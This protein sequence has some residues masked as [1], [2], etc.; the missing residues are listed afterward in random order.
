[1]QRGHMLMLSRS[2]RFFLVPLQAQSDA[3]GSAQELL[4]RVAWGHEQDSITKPRPVN[5]LSSLPFGT[6]I[7]G[8]STLGLTPPPRFWFIPG[9][10]SSTPALSVRR[11]REPTAFLTK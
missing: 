8:P 3:N 4:V 6:G 11:L 5:L 9:L 2:L 7:P 10:R 1:M